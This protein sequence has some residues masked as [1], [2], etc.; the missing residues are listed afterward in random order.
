MALISTALGACGGAE[1]GADLVVYSGRHQDLI[2]PLIARFEKEAGLDVEVRYGPDSA[3]FALQIDAE[4]DRGPDMFLSQSPGAMGFLDEQ[5]RLVALS[6]EVIDAVPEKFR[7]KDGHWVGTSGRVRVVVYNSNNVTGEELPDS[8]FDLTGEQFKGRV[9]IAP[10]NSSFV[11]FVSALRELRGD[12]ETRAFLEGLASNDARDYSD[13]NAVLA[14]VAR[15]EVDF[16]LVNHY[17]N[18]Q[19]KQEDPGQPTENHLFAAEDPGSMLLMTTVGLLKSGEDHRASAE[20][21]VEFLLSEE[22]QKYFAEETLEY[23]LVP[24][25]EAM[26]SDLPQ[27][28]EI[29]V[30]TVDL[31]RLGAEFKST[32]DL[33]ADSG[34]IDG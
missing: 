9:G 19:A 3:A 27:L 32:Q 12:D 11:D 14:A 2:D 26:V 16:G 29:Q 10:T 6:A 31:A 4:G 7:A 17:Y 15:G 1:G 30:P 22:S 21:L 13:N 25:I 33:I 24:G 18:E 8:V 34:L 5:Q 28:D 20:Q 23:P